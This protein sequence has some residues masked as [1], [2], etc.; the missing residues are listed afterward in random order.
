VLH[1]YIR[2]N[3]FDLPVE[4]FNQG[5]KA[6]KISKRKPQTCG[7]G[8]WGSSSPDIKLPLQVVSKFQRWFPR[9]YI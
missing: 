9:E 3:Y 6:A 7:V 2:F 5:F 4:A 8:P 1:R